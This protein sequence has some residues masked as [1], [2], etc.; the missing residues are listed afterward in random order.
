MG[1]QALTLVRER[2]E[3]LRKYWAPNV[4]LWREVGG[5]RRYGAPSVNL[6]Y[7]SEGTEK[8]W[9]TKC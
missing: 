3:G 7:R 2:G 6:R 5:M 8:V 9:G 1:H 4:N